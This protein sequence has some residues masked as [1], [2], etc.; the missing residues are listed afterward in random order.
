LIKDLNVSPESLKLVEETLG[1]TIED[2]GTA[3]GFPNRTPI[4]Q[5]IRIRINK[6][7]CIK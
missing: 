4:A 3:N 2:T 5:E 6:C 1:E 7:D